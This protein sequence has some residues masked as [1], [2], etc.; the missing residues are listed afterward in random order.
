MG[1][2]IPAT[3]SFER[4]LDARTRMTWGAFCTPRC[5]DGSKAQNTPLKIKSA[6]CTSDFGNVAEKMSATLYQGPSL[7]FAI[8]IFREGAAKCA[9]APLSA[10]VGHFD[11]HRSERK[12]FVL[13]LVS[14][15][16]TQA[17]AKRTFCP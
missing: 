5:C 12:Y 4:Q 10:G 8:L 3:H 7:H 1:G 6:F 2:V 9:V 13:V 16:M 15:K 14:G 11:R 17:K